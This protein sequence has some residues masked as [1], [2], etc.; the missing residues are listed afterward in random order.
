VTD[1][2]Y[3]KS[4]MLEM[5]SKILLSLNFSLTEPSALRFLERYCR[6][7]KLEK[8]AYLLCCYILELTLVDYKFLKYSPSNIAASA[9]YLASK[10]FKRNQCWGEVIA[11]HSKYTENMVRPCSKDMCLVL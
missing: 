7:I 10:I 4:E 6:V 2:T 1:L 3:T 5:E 11:V 9:I 8:K